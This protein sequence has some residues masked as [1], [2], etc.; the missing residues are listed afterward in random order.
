MHL[1][2]RG[3]DDTWTI[4]DE[5]KADL[6]VKHPEETLQLNVYTNKQNKLNSEENLL[7]KTNSRNNF[8]T[9]GQVLKELPG[10]TVK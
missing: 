5:N 9:V 1:P 4:N 7:L 8:V 2:V 6:F 3:D 10:K